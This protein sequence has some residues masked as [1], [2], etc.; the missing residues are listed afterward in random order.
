M[1]SKIAWKIDKLHLCIADIR[2]K[3]RKIPKQEEKKYKM[4]KETPLNGKQFSGHQYQICNSIFLSLQTGN[5]C[6]YI[7]IDNTSSI[8]IVIPFMCGLKEAKKVKDK[9][10]NKGH[11]H[12]EKE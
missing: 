8:N 6:K 10:E 7:S 11:L 2:L 5:V 4:E 12:C 9:R 3:T 1:E